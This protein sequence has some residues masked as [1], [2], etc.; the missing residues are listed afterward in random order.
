VI[1]IVF[2]FI[3]FYVVDF[4]HRPHLAAFVHMIAV[5]IALLLS[6]ASFLYLAHNRTEFLRRMKGNTTEEVLKW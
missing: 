5:A 4:R 6:T 3:M 2:V 1:A